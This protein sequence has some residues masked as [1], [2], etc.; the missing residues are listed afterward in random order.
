MSQSHKKASKRKNGVH[1]L[2][3]KRRARKF[4]RLVAFKKGMASQKVDLEAIPK[5]MK[6]RA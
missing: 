3:R 2:A 4:V 5:E 1:D 6:A